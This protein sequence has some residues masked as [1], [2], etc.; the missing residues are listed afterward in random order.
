MKILFEAKNEY[1]FTEFERGWFMLLFITP[2]CIYDNSEGRDK[3][4]FN[5]EDLS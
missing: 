2:V 1:W 4:Y 5:Y 3:I